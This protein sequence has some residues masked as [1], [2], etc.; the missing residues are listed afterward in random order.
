[1]MLITEQLITVTALTSKPLHIYLKQSQFS[2]IIVCCCLNCIWR[3]LLFSQE[4][5][6]TELKGKVEKFLSSALKSVSQPR[7]FEIYVSLRKCT[8]TKRNI[9]YFIAAILPSTKIIFFFPVFF[10][11]MQLVLCSFVALV[12]ILSEN[13]R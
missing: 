6:S 3:L 2:E 5:W 4:K 8:V 7:L 1:M 11:Q 13:K 12:G 9:S 10:C